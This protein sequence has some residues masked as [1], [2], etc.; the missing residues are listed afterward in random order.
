MDGFL[1]KPAGLDQLSE[2][3]NRFIPAAVIPT[4]AATSAATSWTADAPIDRK[5][6]FD[7]VDNDEAFAEHLMREFLRLNA[8]VMDQL[9][10][11]LEAGWD[12]RAV[13]ALAHR[14]LGS[15]RTVAA[16]ELAAA[17]AELECCAEEDRAAAWTTAWTD[18]RGNFDAVR[19][20]ISTRAETDARR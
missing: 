20:F 18:V 8:P 1:L 15:A 2:V 10:L 5:R 11:Q 12:A 19:L 17:L 16:T 7:L 14:L 13:R 4:P 6:M 9:R 3:L